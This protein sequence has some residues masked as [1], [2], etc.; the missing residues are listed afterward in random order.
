M[1]L[2]KKLAEEQG[3]GLVEYSFIVLFVALMLWLSVRYTPVGNVLA[4]HWSTVSQC[5]DSPMS[6]NSGS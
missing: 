1:N 6:C 5:V 4:G 3:Q 2:K